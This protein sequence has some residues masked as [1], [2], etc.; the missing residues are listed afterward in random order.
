MEEEYKEVIREFYRIY[1]PLQ[2]QH[3]LRLHSRFSI[4]DDGFIEIWEY[5]GEQ[6]KKCIC[7]VKEESDIE[8]Y[9]RA[10]EALISYGK[11]SEGIT[12]AKRAG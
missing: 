11:E 1:R 10:T 8:C 6:R 9:K 5:E 2:W 7:K 4:Y 3:N 12:Y